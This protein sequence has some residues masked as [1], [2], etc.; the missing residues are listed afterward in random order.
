MTEPTPAE[1]ADRRSLPGATRVPMLVCDVA[2]AT[3]VEANAAAA[4]FY[5]YPTSRLA[6][7][8]LAA[9]DP[10]ASGRTLRALEPLLAAPGVVA[11]DHRHAS[12]ASLA[13][14]VTAWAVADRERA[15][16]GCAIT[17][18]EPGS[19]AV[20]EREPGSGVERDREEVTAE[21]SATAAL[22]ASEARHRDLIAALQEGIIAYDAEGRVTEINDAALRMIDSRHSAA[23]GTGAVDLARQYVDELGEPFPSDRLPS[24][25]A[26]RTGRPTERVVV[27]LPQADGTFTWVSS[28]AVPMSPDG[29]GRPIGVVVS[30]TDVTAL[31]DA[32]ARAT[33]SEARVRSLI[34]AA[35][36]ALLVLDAD[37]LIT[38]ANPVADRLFGVDAGALAG[39]RLVDFVPEQ[40]RRRFVA[41]L[42]RL[43][44][45]EHL[46]GEFPG[47]RAD[48]REVVVEVSAGQLPDGRIECIAR[49]VTERRALEGERDRLAL[50]AEQASDAIYVTDLDGRIVYVNRAYERLT[51]YLR[52]EV[53]GRTTEVHR[54]ADEAAADLGVEALL[55]SGGTLAGEITMRTNGGRRFRVSK[56]LVV[57]R[58]RDGVPTGTLGIARDI[59]VERDEDARLANAARM[60]AVAQL[61]GGIAH[62]LNNVLTMIVGYA[63]LLDPGAATQDEIAA[64]VRGIT[65]ATDQAQV[66]TT[67]LL[68]FGRRTFLHPRA[69][70]LR[71]L[72][73]DM[74]PILARAAGPR[75]TLLMSPGTTPVPVRIDPNLFEQAILNLVT[76]ARDA[77]PDGG[78]LRL[79]IEAPGPADD[80][81]A[82]DWATFVVADTGMGMPPEMLARVFEPSYG[83][84]DERV[85]LG[86]AMVHGVI[87]QS[88]GH[89]RIESAPGTGTTFRIH[90]PLTAV[91]VAE[92]A[93]PVARA[94][95]SRSGPATILVAEDE[96]V[97]R[98]VAE[99]TLGSRGY[100]VLP[101]ASGEEA[102]AM[103]AAFPGRIDVLFADV[104]MPGLRGPGLASALLRLRPDMRVILTSGYAEDEIVRRGITSATSEFLAKPYTPG[105]LLQVVERLLG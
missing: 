23:V 14:N 56:R 94:Q 19:G 40:A 96:L 12:G 25:V 71:D 85:G 34:D 1:E 26:L 79:A 4:R 82:G 95:P 49:D 83:K 42:A 98:R 15:L 27:G 58:D 87:E 81:P 11:L 6:G 103:A 59:S 51:G 33:A 47:L 16:V 80:L 38:Y 86:L 10:D 55:A 28:N 90:L 57:L 92:P 78:V 88:G 73:A 53:I 77:M 46:V 3:I 54:G 21:R 105:G 76:N 17:E 24:Q 102:L 62:D 101:A 30:F 50:A 5:G 65:E 75:A 37:G 8:P 100:R 41:A 93:R 18:R 7:L 48:G 97:L 31:R 91:V 39:S 74:Q 29:R 63:T 52:D 64:S 32:I 9:L 89:I 2:S 36:D 61:A 44:R 104:G 43:R 20:T 67:R 66:L 22:R 68:A 13:V 70:D 84:G 99:R 35:T 60:E 69:A 72:V 45:G